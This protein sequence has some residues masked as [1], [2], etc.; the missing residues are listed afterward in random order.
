M[1]SKDIKLTVENV[2]ENLI[3]VNIGKF[4]YLSISRT[5]DGATK[6][7]A[8]KEVYTEGCDEPESVFIDGFRVEDLDLI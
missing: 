2:E 8:Y 4:G 1:E 5:D 3:Y 7:S 6:V